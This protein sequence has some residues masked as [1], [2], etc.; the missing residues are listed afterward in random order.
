MSRIARVNRISAVCLVFTVA[1]VSFLCLTDVGYTRSVQQESTPSDIGDGNQIVPATGQLPV[2]QNY[3]INN[4]CVTP[5]ECEL[6]VQ[7]TQLSFTAIQGGLLPVS[8]NF[9]IMND[10]VTQTLS[11]SLSYGASWLNVSPT[12]GVDNWR[13]IEVSVTE[14]NLIP[15]VYYETIVVEADACDGSPQEVTIEYTVLPAEGPLVRVPDTCSNAGGVLRVPIYVSDL[16][17]LDIYAVELTLNFDPIYLVATGASVDGSMAAVWGPPTYNTSPLGRL[18]IAMAGVESLEGEGILC[19]VEFAM[20]A[21]PTHATIVQITKALFNDYPAGA[22]IDGFWSTCDLGMSGT[23][24]YC[25]EGD[26]EDDDSLA[27]NDVEVKYY[28]TSS[29]SVF[30]DE[31][32]FYEISNGVAG[33]DYVLK[34]EK[35]GDDR[36]VISGYDASMVLRYAVDLLDLEPCALVAADVSGNCTVSAYDASFILR[37]VVGLIDEFPVGKDWTFVPRD[38]DL[39]ISN[40]CSAPDSL[41]VSNLA[42]SLEDLDFNGI[43]YGDVSGNWIYNASPGAESSP[44]ADAVSKL[45]GEMMTVEAGSE[46]VIPIEVEAISEV[47]SATISLNFDNELIEVT[48]VGA[49][50]LTSDF[51]IESRVD[52]GTLKIAMAGS[53]SVSVSGQIANVVFRVLENAS[54]GSTGSVALTE[55]LLDETPLSELGTAARFTVGSQ[56]HRYNLLQNYPNPFNPSTTIGFSLASMSEYRLTIYNVTGQLVRTFEGT[57]DAG[58]HFIVWDASVNSSGVYFYRLEAGD[59]STS[60]KMVLLK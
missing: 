24:S 33:G 49:S 3:V 20:I 48:R 56:P 42:T 19:F 5:T 52:G 13:E 18:A 45:G 4:R 57:A 17:G 22:T 15:D 39:T 8:Q 25:P 36:D 23:I 40:W 38:F 34:P 10:D 16:T 9:V 21:E 59:Y 14:T 50:E 35:S 2:T 7:P 51:L 1:F 58:D 11:W 31:F 55:L 6:I 27:V 44:L 30:T 37:Y 29:G 41:V 43:L 26:C 53:K 46:F 12:S 47:Y 28:G 32:G 60:R 54:E